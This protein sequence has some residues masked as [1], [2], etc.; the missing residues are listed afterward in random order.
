MFRRKPRRVVARSDSGFV[1]VL[2]PKDDYAVDAE[3]D[4]GDVKIVGITRN[5][6]AP[7]SI[8]AQTDSGDVA[9]LA[10]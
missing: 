3:T 10:R 6:R 5:D 9:V 4:S 7:T 2:V 1:Q 8:Q